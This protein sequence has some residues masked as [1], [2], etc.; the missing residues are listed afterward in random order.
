VLIIAGKEGVPIEKAQKKV[1]E[2]LGRKKWLRRGKKVTTGT[3]RRI[4]NTAAKKS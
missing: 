2:T 1:A 4:R 3:L